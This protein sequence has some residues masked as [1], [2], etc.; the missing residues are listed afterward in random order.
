MCFHGDPRV[1]N[2]LEGIQDRPA[3]SSIRHLQGSF[4]PR[5]TRSGKLAACS[6]CGKGHLLPFNLEELARPS[7]DAIDSPP[8]RG[9]RS[10]PEGPLRAD[11]CPR[12][13]SQSREG[14]RQKDEVGQCLNFGQCGPGFGNGRQV[15]PTRG[16]REPEGPAKQGRQTDCFP[17]R[18]LLMVFLANILKFI[19]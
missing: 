12:I 5:A 3:S 1:I 10:G 9:G 13:Y 6:S 4:P 7:T 8:S 14:P 11:R 2:S 19:V 16:G 15:P 18:T 17:Y